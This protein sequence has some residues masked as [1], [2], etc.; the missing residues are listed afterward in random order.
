MCAQANFW[1]L[2]FAFDV[3]VS[4]NDANQ[5]YGNG[6]HQI[7]QYAIDIDSDVMK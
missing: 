1:T 3:R 5:M 6:S 2:R 7:V 4:F